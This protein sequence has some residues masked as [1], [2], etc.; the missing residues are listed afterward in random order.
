MKSGGLLNYLR[1]FCFFTML[2][3]DMQ[4]LFSEV[5]IPN[6]ST[7]GKM[8]ISI[9]ILFLFYSDGIRKL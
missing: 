5:I 4:K 3:I 9:K 6:Y 7:D 2:E 1:E 8:W